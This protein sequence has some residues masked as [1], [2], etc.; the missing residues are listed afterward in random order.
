MKPF[1]LL[2]LSCWLPLP[3]IAAVLPAAPQVAGSAYILIDFDSQQ[4]IAA[5]NPDLQV[6]PASLTK[7]MT[8]YIA[9]RE[10]HSGKLDANSSLRVSEKAWKMGGSRMF[11]EVDT[12]VKVSD[13]LRGIIIQSGNDASVAIAEH[14]AGSED[15]FA[16]LMNH[17]A[18]S[19]GMSNSYF[20]NST[21]WPA[22]GHLTSARDMA[23]LA[24]AIIAD[25]S[26]HYKLYSEKWFRYNNIRQP[27][28]NRLLWRD[29]S[30]DGLKTGHTEAAGYCLVASAKREGM[31]LISLV[32]GTQSDEARAQE[33]QKLLT[34]GF[35][36]Y[37]THQLATNNEALQQG[38]VWLGNIDQVNV[39]LTEDLHVTIPRG[40]FNALKTD[41]TLDETLE[42][43]IQAGQ[44]LGQLSVSYDGEVLLQR[45]LVALHAVE[46]G[47]FFSRLWDRILRLFQ[48]IFG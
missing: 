45:P 43:P 46:P 24:T 31:R 5:S 28:R 38:K 23:S 30:V 27:K 36:F 11:I 37:K 18:R 2:W 32:M 10:I 15:A 48:A 16:D 22:D 34:Y 19:L 42:A 8:A 12:Q 21:G 20:V 9:S 13:I 40:A 4:V 39:G 1:L 47:S 41:I 7:M 35:R 17:Y 33:S 25:Y 44:T 26:E 14:I 3:L 6:E 29:K